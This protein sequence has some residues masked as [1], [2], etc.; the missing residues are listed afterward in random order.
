M[1]KNPEYMNDVPRNKG[2]GTSDDNKSNNISLADNKNKD[3]KAN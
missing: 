1:Y 2:K 3:S